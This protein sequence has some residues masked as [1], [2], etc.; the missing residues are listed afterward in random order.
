MSQYNVY[1]NTGFQSTSL[2]N[3]VYSVANNK[4]VYIYIYIYIYTHTHIHT[5]LSEVNQKSRKNTF[6][7][8]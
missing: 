1:L 3:S 7:M 5:R 2:F 8:I 4:I 6:N